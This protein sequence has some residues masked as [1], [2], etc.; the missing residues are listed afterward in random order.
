MWD[1]SS[2]HE[3]LQ[4][5]PPESVLSQVYASL[6]DDPSRLVAAPEEAVGFL[7]DDARAAYFGAVDPFAGDARL[8][9]LTSLP[10]K[11][12]EQVRK[13]RINSNR[14]IEKDM[15]NCL[16]TIN[17][18]VRAGGVWVAKGLRADPCV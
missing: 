9:P 18:F 3:M 13:L 5:A 14:K 16:F 8:L 11:V 2:Y 6:S 7:L 4:T 17:V 12:N 15:G 1:S 10:D